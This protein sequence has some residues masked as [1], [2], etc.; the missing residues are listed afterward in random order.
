MLMLNLG[1]LN[2]VNSSVLPCRS[3]YKVYHLHLV[4]GKCTALRKISLAS[5]AIVDSLTFS[6]LIFVSPTRVILATNL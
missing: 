2:I 3:D 6:G 1:T 5:A 4:F